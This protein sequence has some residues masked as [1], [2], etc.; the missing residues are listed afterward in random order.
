MHRIILALLALTRYVQPRTRTRKIRKQFTDL[1]RR[2]MIKIKMTY[3]KESEVKDLLEIIKEKVEIKKM[4][5]MPD[6]KRKRL[7]IWGEKKL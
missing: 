4:K 3:D 6:E 5:E 7:C 1:E 2:A